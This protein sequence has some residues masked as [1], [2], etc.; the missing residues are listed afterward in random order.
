[1]A[2]LL[3]VS[4]E[5]LKYIGKEL[6]FQYVWMMDEDDPWPGVWALMP[7]EVSFGWVPEFDLQI[8]Q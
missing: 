6:I 2:C 8:I 5:A 4:K 7:V 3:Y 1:M